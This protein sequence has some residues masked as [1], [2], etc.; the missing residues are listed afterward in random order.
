MAAL[1]IKCCAHCET[2]RE[3]ELRRMP[4]GGNGVQVKWQCLTCGHAIGPAVPHATV[5]D[6]RTLSEWDASFAA[7]EREAHA[8]KRRVW[9]AGTLERQEKY[10]AYLLTAAWRTRR[11][12]VLERARGVCE[13]CRCQDAAE[14]HHLS[15]IHIY[16]EFLFE[17]V[18]LCRDCHDRWHAHVISRGR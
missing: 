8:E 11:R 3:T 15:Y 9:D 12:L 1:A 2:D 18:A 13:G 6:V 17:L 14:V 7:R 5:T 16:Q 4:I 10:R